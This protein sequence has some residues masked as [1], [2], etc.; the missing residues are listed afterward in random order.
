MAETE[1]PASM[2]TMGWSRSSLRPGD[3]ITIRVITV[4]NAKP[5]GRIVYVQPATG[6]KLQG[7]INDDSK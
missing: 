3:E 7:R 5:I 4:R 2:T 6:P 1:N